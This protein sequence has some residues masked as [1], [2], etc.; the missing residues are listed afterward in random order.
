MKRAI[1]WVRR[2]FHRDAAWQEEIESHLAMRAA[3][4]VS[5]AS[6]PRWF[7]ATAASL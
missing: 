3:W 6:L 1:A 7:T 2:V 5:L 4:P